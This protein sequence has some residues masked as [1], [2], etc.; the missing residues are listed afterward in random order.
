MLSAYCRQRNISKILSWSCRSWV[1]N[2]SEASQRAKIKVK[3][4][5]HIIPVASQPTSLV[6]SFRILPLIPNIPAKLFEGGKKAQT[7]K[8]L[9]RPSLYVWP[10]DYHSSRRTHFQ[11]HTHRRVI[12]ILLYQTE[13]LSN[14]P[15][16]PLYVGSIIDPITFW[17]YWF[18][19][20]WL[21]S[22]W[23]VSSLGARIVPVWL[24]DYIVFFLFI[25]SAWHIQRLNKWMNKWMNKP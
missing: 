15:P 1:K 13:F 5:H 6:S 9:I 22:P 17:P 24:K 14:V 2:P 11:N 21:P 7:V 16:S 4:P 23:T 20:T 19:F 10:G 25:P 8:D 3:I 12:L 18:L